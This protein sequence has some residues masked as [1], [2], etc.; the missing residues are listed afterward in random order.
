MST[1]I[2][3]PEPLSEARND[4]RWRA[5]AERDAASDG[6]FVYGV[7]ST[8][9]FCR[10]SCPSRRPRRDRVRFFDAPAEARAA[11]YRPCRRCHPEAPAAD[12]A[13]RIVEVVCRTLA[14]E[15][16]T[17]PSLAD[18]A[19][20]AGVSPS[21]LQRVFTRATGLSPRRYAEALRRD[22]LTAGLRQGV[23][24]AAALY[25]AGYGSS[26]RLYEKSGAHLGMTPASYAKGGAGAR[27]AFATA[28]SPLGRLLVAA[29]ERG[30]CAVSLG[31]SD[32]VL[33]A[34][35]RVDFPAAAIARDDGALAGRLA[36]VLGHLGGRLPRL[37]LPLDVRAT[38]FQWKVWRAL[39]AIPPGETLSYGAIAARLGQPS[40]AR[41]VGRACATNPVAL[42]VPCHRAVGGDGRLTGYRWGVERKRRLLALE[43]AGRD[44]PVD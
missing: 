7:V 39:T 2:Q 15:T 14:E 43:K 10:P 13:K 11:G 26:S 18:L 40:A 29:T 32:A 3:L 35:L 22:R 16:E 42:I 27:I 20:A 21:H 9:V 31:D 4:A 33:E 34:T 19:A 24:V 36:A 25:D 41:A 37:D 8:G 17:I 23:P 28:A 38:A 12:P 6:Q 30:V 5:V 44:K 1:M